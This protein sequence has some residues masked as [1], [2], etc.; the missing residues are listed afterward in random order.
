MLGNQGK[1]N[2]KIGP[3]QVET[4]P[5]KQKMQNFRDKVGHLKSSSFFDQVTEN[6]QLLCYLEKHARSLENDKVLL[7]S[8]LERFQEVLK[9]ELHHKKL[10]LKQLDLLK[11]EGEAKI[12]T[13]SQNLEKKESEYSNL[14]KD[15]NNLMDQY[16]NIGTSLKTQTENSET[17]SERF[18][19]KINNFKE[20]IQKLTAENKDL[21]NNVNDLQIQ[22]ERDKLQWQQKIDGLIREAQAREDLL[23]RHHQKEVD[24]LK[25]DF[26]KEKTEL[27]I[28]IDKHWNDKLNLSSAARETEVQN[29]ITVQKADLEKANKEIDELKELIVDLRT[30]NEEV[31]GRIKSSDTMLI[32]TQAELENI[33]KYREN[34]NQAWSDRL[35]KEKEELENL[36]SQRLETEIETL[37]SV[38]EDEI[39]GYKE[40]I[41]VFEAILENKMTEIDKIQLRLAKLD[42][43]YSELKQKYE[44]MKNDHET[45]IDNYNQQ[46]EKYK[47]TVVNPRDNDAIFKAE[48]AAYE[49]KI[50]QLNV[51]LE[52]LESKIEYLTDEKL[53]AEQVANQRLLELQKAREKAN[54]VVKEEPNS[55]LDQ[56][57]FT[58]KTENE[59]FKYTIAQEKK[60]QSTLMQK[61]KNLE[62]ELE[63]CNLS[64]VDLAKTIE[65]HKH[66]SI[67]N[68]NEIKALKAMIARYTKENNDFKNSTQ[69][70]NEQAMELQRTLTIER[71]QKE[72]AKKN[73]DDAQKELEV[74]SQEL[75][76]NL[77]AL[78]ELK[79]QYY[80]AFNNCE[81]LNFN[82]TSRKNKK[83]QLDSKLDE[84][85]DD[86]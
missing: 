79:R 9:G 76:E 23:S 67:L 39:K 46:I 44:D 51:K 81:S 11:M 37:T 68:V 15:Y 75:I 54:E 33:K 6:N 40:R 5:F 2:S 22:S 56:Q 84:I 45:E 32:N 8:E 3:P 50:K 29:L 80:D 20:Q 16:T 30:D 62:E 1:P 78:D 58:L 26:D 42:K 77:K 7:G 74:K 85:L 48:R 18:K 66:E 71:K 4:Q 28:R 13:L 64:N 14:E 24:G 72:I 36:S 47:R 59:N 34:E 31:N 70:L 61:I 55:L 53:N 63:N 69:L 83:G 86:E 19:T 60:A 57:I 52:D 10:L 43:S 17:V 38:F 25:S 27:L 65:Q 82:T 12:N 41:S 73:A 49:L 21:G 35:A